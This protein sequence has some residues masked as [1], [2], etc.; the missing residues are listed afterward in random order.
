MSFHPPKTGVI[1]RFDNSIK[2]NIHVKIKNIEMWERIDFSVTVLSVHTHQQ[3]ALVKR[4]RLL[5]LPTI[6]VVAR[7]LAGRGAVL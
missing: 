3:H 5:T 1:G 4:H 2:R 6:P 7:F